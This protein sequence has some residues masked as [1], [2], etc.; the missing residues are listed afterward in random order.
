ME[1]NETQSVLLRRLVRG[2]RTSLALLA[3]NKKIFDNVR[4]FFPYPYSEKNAAEFI[5]LC[6]NEDPA[7][8]YAVEFQQQLAGVIGLVLQTDV[9]R[10]SA[11]IGYWIGEPFWNKGIASAAVNQ[12]VKYAFEELKLIRVFTGVFDFNIASQRVLEKCGFEL[13]GI[14]KKS[15]IKNGNVCNEYRYAKFNNIRNSVTSN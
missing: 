11:E 13:E 4:D 2:D 8:T 1:I 12:M 7:V 3:N 9:Y 6:L 15:I 5:E 10:K 14:F